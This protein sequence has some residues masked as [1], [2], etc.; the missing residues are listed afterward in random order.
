MDFEGNIVGSIA[1]KNI[2][3]FAATK[4]EVWLL[5][6]KRFLRID[7]QNGTIIE[8]SAISKSDFIAIASSGKALAK[9]IGKKVEVFRK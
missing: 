4:E 1:A 6:N 7:A 8:E 3:S 2:H 9:I 5:E